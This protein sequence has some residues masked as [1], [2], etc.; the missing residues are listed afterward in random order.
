MGR[1][2]TYRPESCPWA[3]LQARGLISA[4]MASRYRTGAGYPGRDRL[5][6]FRALGYMV[7][8]IDGEAKCDEWPEMG[9]EA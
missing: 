8:V 5:L 2:P 6:L 7:E 9:G 4:Q 3:A 1:G